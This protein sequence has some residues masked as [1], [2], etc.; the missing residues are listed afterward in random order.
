MQ[1]VGCG[2][3]G[4][5]REMARF[6]GASIVGI[7]NNAYQIQRASLLTARA[8]LQAQ[9]SYVQVRC[10]RGSAAGQLTLF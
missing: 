1:D 5:L 3:G 2:I 8:G 10:R 7:N 6:S 9:C 4:P